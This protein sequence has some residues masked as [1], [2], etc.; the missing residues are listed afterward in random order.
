LGVWVGTVMVSAVERGGDRPQCSPAISCMLGLV[1]SCMLVLV[2]SSCLG[3]WCVVGVSQARLAAGM[4]PQGSGNGS[5]GRS[6]TATRTTASGGS[7]G[8]GGSGGSGGRLD[9][10]RD[11]GGVGGG[12]VGSVGATSLARKPAPGS[13]AAAEQWR[14]VPIFTCCR[15]CFA[16][17]YLPGSLPVTYLVRSNVY[18][19]VHA[20]SL[21]HRATYSVG[22]YW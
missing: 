3:W 21:S 22:G 1:V 4:I 6:S 5:G 16:P 18:S 17:C 13:A 11:G 12:N 15:R 19:L 8:C 14:S 10:A 2:V 7:G 20:H 9:R